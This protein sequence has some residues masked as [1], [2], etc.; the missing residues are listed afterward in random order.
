MRYLARNFWAGNL[1]ERLGAYVN[2][3]TYICMQHACKYML[4]YTLHTSIHKVTKFCVCLYVNFAYTCVNIYMY[5]KIFMNIYAYAYIQDH[6]CVYVPYIHTVFNVYMHISYVIYVYVYIYM[7]IYIQ[8]YTTYTHT[9]THTHIYPIC[10]NIV[11][12]QAYLSSKGVN[13]TNVQHLMCVCVMLNIYIHVCVYIY[14]YIYIYMYI[15]I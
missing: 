11:Y 2:A 14:I 6:V 7:Q 10:K 8:T 3:S 9:H 1:E 4:T 13:C 12:I 5:I 15:Y